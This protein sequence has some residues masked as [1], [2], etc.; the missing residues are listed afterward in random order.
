LKWIRTAFEKYQAIG[1][2]RLFV[3]AHTDT[4]GSKEH[5]RALS[6]R[7]A[8]AIAEWF[9]QNGLRLPIAYQGFGEQA[10]KVVTADEVDEIQNRRVDY[11]LSIDPPRFKVS[12]TVLDWQTL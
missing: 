8:R 12:G 7:R 3:A 5:N 10:L 1:P 11:M 9:R 2:I 6:L 4:R